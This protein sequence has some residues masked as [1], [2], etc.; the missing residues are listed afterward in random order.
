MN[1]TVQ[2]YFFAKRLSKIV[3]MFLKIRYN[4]FIKSEGDYKTMFENLGFG[5]VLQIGDIVKFGQYPQGT[6]GEVLS[7]EWRVLEVQKDKVLLLSD[8]LLDYVRYNQECAD[9]T[10][11]TCTLRK[12]MNND[13]I[14]RA[15]NSE[16]QDKIAIVTNRNTTNNGTKVGND[17]QDKVFALSLDEV[18][19]YFPTDESSIAYTTDYAHTQGYDSEDRSDFWW[20]RTSGER[21]DIAMHVDSD[22]S[23]YG[24]VGVESYNIPVRLALWINFQ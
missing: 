14:Q 2:A 10:W 15:F 16:E 4:Y 20:M 21:G 19:K 23:I 6:N 5:T 8:R 7:I 24:G 18:K 11:E 22:G 9:V 12:W 17:T 13:F 3:V 1:R